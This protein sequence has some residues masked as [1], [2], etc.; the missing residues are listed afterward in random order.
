MP[1]AGNLEELL[2]VK[3]KTSSNNSIRSMDSDLLNLYKV[4]AL[5]ILNLLKVVLRIY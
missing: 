4:V 1:I 5:K 2:N 3:V